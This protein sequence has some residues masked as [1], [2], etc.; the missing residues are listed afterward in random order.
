MVFGT[1]G[2]ALAARAKRVPGRGAPARTL[3]AV[4]QGLE[5]PAGAATP[6][7]LS[8]GAT[9]FGGA[10]L[11]WR[12]CRG[13]ARRGQLACGPLGQSAG[14]PQRAR[15]RA[16][17]REAT[18]ADAGR[19]A[20]SSASHALMSTLIPRNVPHPA[21]LS[22]PVAVHLRPKTRRWHLFILQLVIASRVPHAGDFGTNLYRW[23]RR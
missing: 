11:G 16:V 18:P 9:R 21:S 17:G 3:G 10:S 15:Q 2:W 7:T 8:H 14:R 22:V 4:E 6:P 12:G 1:L 5:R 23:P 19:R 20:T 13:A